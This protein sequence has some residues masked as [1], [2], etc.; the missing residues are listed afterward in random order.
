[1]NTLILQTALIRAQQ[2]GGLQKVAFNPLGWA[3]EKLWQGAGAAVSPY[4]VQKREE[5]YAGGKSV[6]PR[7]ARLFQPAEQEEGLNEP[8]AKDVFQAPLPQ[9]GKVNPAL[10]S[11][12]WTTNPAQR[13]VQEVKKAYGNPAATAAE[14]FKKQFAPYLK[15]GGAALAAM[16]AGQAYGVYTQSQQTEALQQM[17]QQG[18][19]NPQAYMTGYQR[20]MSV[21]RPW[22]VK[23][24]TEEVVG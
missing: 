13:A 8:I 16:L 4:F 6:G 7:G 14:Q 22:P 3:G 1:V 21:T 17:A 2:R 11:V 23:Q 15:W 5:G 10:G 24:V 12:N 18:R 19:M 9:V 20:P